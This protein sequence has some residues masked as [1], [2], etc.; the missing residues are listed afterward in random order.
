MTEGENR[1]KKGKQ[2]DP[3]MDLQTDRIVPGTQ[4]MDMSVINRPRGQPDTKA[5]EPQ[6]SSFTIVLEDLAFCGVLSKQQLS[7]SAFR[8]YTWEVRRL[9]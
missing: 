3:L 4:S 8:L 1:Y 2:M 9:D 6:N 7:F 5:Q